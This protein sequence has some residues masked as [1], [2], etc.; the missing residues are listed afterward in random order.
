MPT[1]RSTRPIWILFASILALAVFTNY[2]RF[3]QGKDLVPWRTDFAAAQAEAQRTRKPMMAY[4]TA[5]WCGYCQD[6]HRTTWS[7]KRVEQALGNYVPVMIDVD[8]HADLARRFNISAMPSYA[9]LDEQGKVLRQGEGY[10]PARDFI[11][12]LGH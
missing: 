5:S 3:R 10:L 6:M 11:S 1:T 8:E 2:S 4:F 12:W 9:V 7:D